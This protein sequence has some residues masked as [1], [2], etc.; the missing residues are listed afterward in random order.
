VINVTNR[1]DVYVRLVSFK[2]FFSHLSVSPA[3]ILL[4]NPKKSLAHGYD[5]HSYIAQGPPSYTPDSESQLSLASKV[6]FFAI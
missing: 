1:A 3:G 5:I 6:V 4:I 2:F